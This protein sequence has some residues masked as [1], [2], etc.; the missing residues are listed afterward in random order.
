MKSLRGRKNFFKDLGND[1]GRNPCPD[2][3]YVSNY[4][5]YLPELPSLEMILS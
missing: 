3:T 4:Q 5:Y 1:K 2:Y